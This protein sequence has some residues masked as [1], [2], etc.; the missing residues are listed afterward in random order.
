MYRNRSSFFV[1]VIFLFVF[2]LSFA[3]QVF[4]S[5]VISSFLLNGSA[6]N[7]TF[8]PNNGESV[9]IDVRANEPVKFTR[10]Y[11]CSVSQICNGTSGNYTRYFTQSDISD[12]I[13]KTWN[14]KKTGDTEIVPAGEYKI[15]VSMTEGTNDPVTAFGQYS[16]FVDFSSVN[17]NGTSSNTNTN[18]TSTTNNSSGNSSTTTVIKRTVYVSAHSSTEDLSNYSDMSSF[19]IS[20]GRERMALIGTP[21]AFDAKYNLL[22]KNSCSPIFKWS[23]G[24]GL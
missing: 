23:F 10:L 5:P 9:S 14:G 22:D 6:G 15:M 8:N 2:T 19:E 7:I 24:D 13:S 21:L 17:N 11:I 18:A 3:S 16:I 1:F 12:A 4:A 20:A